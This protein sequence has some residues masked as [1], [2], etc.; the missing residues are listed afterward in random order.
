MAFA[1]A[2][3]N[4]RNKIAENANKNFGVAKCAASILILFYEAV[5][6]GKVL[7]VAYDVE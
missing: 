6:V 2:A 1:E 7:R 5:R 3:T 4:Y